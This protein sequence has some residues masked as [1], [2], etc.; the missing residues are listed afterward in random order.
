MGAVPTLGDLPMLFRNLPFYLLTLPLEKLSL[1]KGRNH[2]CRLIR[3]VGTKCYPPKPTSQR[4]RI[5][6][7]LTATHPALP[8]GSITRSSTGSNL[9]PKQGEEL[10]LGSP[11]ISLG[12]GAKHPAR[13]SENPPASSFTS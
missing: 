13:V 6:H 10:G 2:Y 1:E 4:E 5:S 12:L 3:E 7:E 11:T 9:S 8:G